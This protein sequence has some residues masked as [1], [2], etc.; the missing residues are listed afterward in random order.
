MQIAYI[1][2]TSSVQF[3]Y[4]TLT[5]DGVLLDVNDLVDQ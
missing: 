4:F 2:R 5:D 3:G 1:F